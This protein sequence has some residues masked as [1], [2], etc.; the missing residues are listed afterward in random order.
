MQICADFLFVC[1]ARENIKY[2]RLYTTYTVFQQNF[3]DLYF[4]YIGQHICVKHKRH[5]LPD[6]MA[7]GTQTKV[8]TLNTYEIDLNSA[9]RRAMQSALGMFMK[10]CEYFNPI[11]E[12][13]TRKT[14]I[15][16]RDAFKGINYKDN[17][18]F[19]FIR[20][21]KIFYPRGGGQSPE[22]L[23]LRILYKRRNVNRQIPLFKETQH[24]RFV[25]D[26]YENIPIFLVHMFFKLIYLYSL[27]RYFI[28]Y[29]DNLR[30][31]LLRGY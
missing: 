11:S 23:I 22:M 28:E 30:G 5:V 18:K 27:C 7:V 16:T 20:V 26:I 14:I 3:P 6:L 15:Y 10:C 2:I 19:I 17:Q 4:V 25:S 29:F 12:L 21:Q 24:E 31:G 13:F 8:S 1:G 9:S